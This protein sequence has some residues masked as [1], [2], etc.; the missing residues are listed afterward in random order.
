MVVEGLFCGAGTTWFGVHYVWRGAVCT[1]YFVSKSV[2]SAR[3]D[4]NTDCKVLELTLVER[5]PQLAR[6][7]RD[8]HYDSGYH[9]CR[10]TST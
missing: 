4:R 5:I 3:E 2:T 6:A 7:L 8:V 1:Q 10:Y 9:A